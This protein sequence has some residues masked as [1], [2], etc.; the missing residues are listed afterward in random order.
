MNDSA[1]LIKKLIL[2]FLVVAGLYLAEEF[3][4]PLCLGGLLAALFLPFCKWMET[5]KIPKILAVFICLLVLLSAIIGLLMLLSWQ[6]SKLTGDLTFL[7]QKAID[8]FD[9]IQLY[10]FHHFGI[11]ASAQSQLIKDQQT[12]FTGFV[13]SLFGSMKNIFS[14]FILTVVYFFL[15]LYYRSHI[16]NF[17]L[18]LAPASQREE[19]EHVIYSAAKVSTQYL[20]GLSKM[21]VCLW[22]MYSIGF[23]IVGVDNAIFFAVLCG[24][25]EIVPFIGNLTGTSITVLVAVA[26]GASLAMLGGIVITYGVVQFIQGWVLEPL[27]LGPHVKIN[28]LFT[29]LALVIGEIIWG[30]PGIVL[31]IPLTAILKIICDHVES[32][33][34]YGFLIGEIETNH[35]PPKFISKIKSWFT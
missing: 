5:K 25:L 28:P 11:S 18:K 27:I 35:T 26:H 1:A 14:G 19:T 12:T 22:I 20:Q 17:M 32:M 3:L 29:I 6:V 10:I 33:K 7:K 21:I 30:I 23:S 31:A 24:L 4:I 13:E 2:I 15:L 34:P 8:S 16:K 9:K